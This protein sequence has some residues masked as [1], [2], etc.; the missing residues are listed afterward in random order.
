[1]RKGQ[2]STEYLII[3]AVVIVIALIVIGVMGGIP[4]IGTAGQSRTSASYWAT[5]DVGII[6]H[7]VT[8]GTD[9]ATII[10]RNNI[11]NQ[12]QITALTLDGSAMDP[13]PSTLAPG[14]TNTFNLTGATICSNAGDSYSLAVSVTYTNT[15]TS[16]GY[17]FTGEGTKL[18]GT[19]AT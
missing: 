10:V 11:P 15:A 2:A 17:T 12:I 5:A 4:G 18:D 19:C 14:S 3:L 13:V 8:T 6:S 1:M 16:A 7:S 9:T